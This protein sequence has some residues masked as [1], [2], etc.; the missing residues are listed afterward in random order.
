MLLVD[1]LNISELLQAAEES[2]S[3]TQLYPKTIR[4]GIRMYPVEMVLR[5]FCGLLLC[6]CHRKTPVHGKV[7]VQAA[8]I[9]SH[10]GDQTYSRHSNRWLNV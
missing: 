10:C 6:R 5:A 9:V 2:D 4:L 3:E 7:F 8:G 1:L